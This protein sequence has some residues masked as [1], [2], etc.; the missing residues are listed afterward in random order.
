M[1]MM[2]KHHGSGVNP[3]FALEAVHTPLSA[4]YTSIVVF[5]FVLTFFLHSRSLY[6]HYSTSLFFMLQTME[7]CMPS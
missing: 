5:I 4:P 6:S 3:S 2:L 7:N 1:L